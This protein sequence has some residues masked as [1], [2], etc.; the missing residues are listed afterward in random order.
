MY[1]GATYRIGA[2][3]EVILSLGA[4]HTPKV[5][6]QSGIGDESDLQRLGI[7]V[8]Q[9]LPG[10][11]CHFQDHV[12]F[13]CVWEY[14]TPLAPRNNMSEAILFGTSKAGLDAPD[15]FVC[16]AEVPKSTA[17]NAARFGLP[18]F[19][20]TFFGAVAH[21]QSRG[22]LRFAGPRPADPIL[23]EANTLADSA[24]LKAAIA[25]IELCCEI[26][27][28]SPI[29]PF[30]KREVMPGNLKG[31]ELERFV[32]D[33]ATSFW[34]EVGTAR[35]GRDSMSVVDNH[36]KVYGVDKLRIAD[37]SILPRVTTA[38][39]MAPCVIVGEKAAQLICAA[40][41]LTALAMQSGS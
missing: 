39:T 19:G 21:P 10:V 16:Q 2:T 4:I 24:D 12:A 32:R 9:H 36:L 14:H 22:R 35:M 3:A 29:R 17:E 11:G 26:G 33:A 41:S 7:E 5:L 1:A 15:L 25:C 6:M 23:I 40:H 31:L 30:V 8:V 37:G 13:D 20:W 18:E 28:S 27:N 38:N 34:H